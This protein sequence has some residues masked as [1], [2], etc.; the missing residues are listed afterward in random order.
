MALASRNDGSTLS[1]KEHD[2]CKRTAEFTFIHNCSDKE[3]SGKMSLVPGA[4]NKGSLKHV[5]NTIGRGRS[6]PEPDK[7]AIILVQYSR[8]KFRV[9]IQNGKKDS[10]DCKIT[11]F[12]HVDSSLPCGRKG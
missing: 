7:T 6:K 4:Q 2:A 10:P 12:R 3:N 5:L 1:T 11:E 9:R 8:K